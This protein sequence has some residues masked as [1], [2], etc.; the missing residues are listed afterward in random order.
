MERSKPKRSFDPKA[1]NST[2]AS[3]FAKAQ[4]SPIP[5]AEYG[6]TEIGSSPKN[7]PNRAEKIGSSQI[8]PK[9][10]PGLKR[11]DVLQNKNDF[12]QIDT[13]IATGGMAIIW[14]AHNIKNKQIIVVKQFM[15]SKYY[16]PTTNKNN[17]EE[18]WQRERDIIQKQ[19][20]SP[21]TTMKCLDAIK[22][23][24]LGEPEYYLLLEYIE[25]LSLEEWIYRQPYLP[26]TNEELIFILEQIILPLCNHLNYIH[27]HGIIHRDITP[28]NIV[29]TTRNEQTIPILI[30]WGVAKEKAVDEMFSPQ[31]PYFENNFEETIG[32]HSVGNPPEELGGFEPVA[33][34]DIYMLGNILFA[35]LTKGMKFS[36]PII[37]QDYILHPNEFNPN[38]P[39][40]LNG[41]VEAMTQYEPADRIPNC[42]SII[43][44]ITP[45]LQTLPESR[46]TNTG[47]RK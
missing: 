34:T 4:E 40:K 17:C 30:D 2:N 26:S 7:V 23:T 21:S 25:G 41:L 47:L 39:T 46:T 32:I 24:D 44:Q 9:K 10:H 22:S 37:T 6:V 12:Y 43:E 29:L 45:I 27:E 42:Q 3:S 36:K 15:T 14:K 19:S 18:Y 11:G 28:K 20:L 35:L 31:K 16:D 38:I 5:S 13:R 1:K 8:Q 33:A